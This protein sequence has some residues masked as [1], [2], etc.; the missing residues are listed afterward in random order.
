V[1]FGDGFA[2]KEVKG[3][4][5]HTQSVFHALRGYESR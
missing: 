3:G 2:G 4:V 5:G 1:A